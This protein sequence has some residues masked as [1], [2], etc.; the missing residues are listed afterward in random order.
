M[1]VT[2]VVFIFTAHNPQSIY[3]IRVLLFTIVCGPL[4]DVLVVVSVIVSCRQH[5]SALTIG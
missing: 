2:L 4:L 1:Q 5:L 3:E